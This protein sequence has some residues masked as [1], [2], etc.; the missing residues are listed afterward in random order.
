MRVLT[1]ARDFF[2]RHPEYG[3][4]GGELTMSTLTSAVMEDVVEHEHSDIRV[5]REGRSCA[6]EAT[7]DWMEATFPVQELFSRIVPKPS[8]SS[9]VNHRSEVLIGA[10]ATGFT[11]RGNAGEHAENLPEAEVPA[12]LHRLKSGGRYL[13]FKV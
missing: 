5:Q 10:F 7:H 4:P 6:I 12:A 3:L 11:T 8:T 9:R 2:R 13:V 1:D